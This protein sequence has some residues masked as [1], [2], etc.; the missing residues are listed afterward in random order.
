MQVAAEPWDDRATHS[1]MLECIS[2]STIGSTLT[3]A[4]GS[5]VVLDN[6]ASACQIFW[7]VGSSATIDTTTSFE[8]TIMAL[9]SISVNNGAVIHGRAL[10]RTGAVTLINDTV[11]QPACGEIASNTTVT[12]S[13]R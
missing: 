1:A 12:S 11:T 13:A 2:I 8:G 7:Q 4:P 6:N 5:S 9:A 10:A 3:S